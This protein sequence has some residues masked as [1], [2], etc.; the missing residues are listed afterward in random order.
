MKLVTTFLL[1]ALVCFSGLSV[2]TIAQV[3]TGPSDPTDPTSPD[4]SEIDELLFLLAL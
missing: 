3:S 2:Q 4:C 1:S